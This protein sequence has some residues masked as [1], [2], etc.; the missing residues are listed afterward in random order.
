MGQSHATDEDV[1]IEAPADF[2]LLCPKDQRLAWGLDG[3]FTPEDRWMLR[4]SSVDFEGQG[5]EPGKVVQLLGPSASFKPPGEAVVVETV[6]GSVVVVRRKGQD[7]G[8]GQPPGPVG[9]VT[10]VEF[11]VTTLGPQLERA[12]EELSRRLGLNEEDSGELSAEDTGALRD[13]VVSAV[14][15][16]QYMVMGRET[17]GSGDVFGAKAVLWKSKLEERL[18]RIVLGA[19]GGET[20]VGRERSW[21]C[22]RIG[23]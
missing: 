7:A 4:S 18:S 8:V 5:I 17:G 23:R 2:P 21:F 6:S 12:S 10:G 16:Q 19:S 3:V 15:A 1:V 20:G 14:L 13:V 22:T 9:G 11:V